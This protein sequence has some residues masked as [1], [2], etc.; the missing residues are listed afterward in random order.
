MYATL[1]RHRLRIAWAGFWRGRSAGARLGTLLA[2]LLGGGAIL[3]FVAAFAGATA[4]SVRETDPALLGALLSALFGTLAL[5][6]LSTETSPILHQLY[7]S[8]DIDLLLAAPVPA[9]SLFLLKLTQCAL[10]GAVTGIV[11]VAALVGYGVATGGA[12]PFYLMALPVIALV[13][14][15][16]TAATMIVLMLLTR[17]APAG[18]LRGVAGVLGALFGAVVW[19]LFQLASNRGT[20][21]AGR[22]TPGLERWQNISRPLPTTWAANALQTA[23]DGRYGAAA[24][25]IALLVGLTVA[26]VALAG[27]VFVRTFSDGHGRLNDVRPH[28]PRAV[29]RSNA[30]VSALLVQP[31]SPPVR[32]VILKEWRTLRR[33]V[34]AVTA[35][36]F[37]LVMVSFFG[38]RAL[39]NSPGGSDLSHVALF[40]ISLAPAAALPWFAGSTLATPALGREGRGIELLRSTPLRTRAL[41]IGKMVA[42]AAPVTVL[43]WVITVGV[44]VWR[45][46]GVPSVAVALVMG[47]WLAGGTTAADVAAGA[48][49]PRFEQDNPQRAVGFAGSI[50]GLVL[51]ALFLGSSAGLFGWLIAWALG[52]VSGGTATL[53]VSAVLAGIVAVVVAVILGVAALAAGRLDRWQDE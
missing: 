26:L 15:L 44:G 16:V 3:F 23:G 27:W 48:L 46:A 12:L 6:V 22:I 7:L 50:L 32:A 17:V 29:R 38:L 30:G 18:R 19:V 1:L 49:T 53:V 33:D 5:F 39:S 45:G 2:G 40:W 10:F 28:G 34:R 43:V 41:L 35:L 14:V 4:R 21:D 11:N 47:M 51:S 20:R 31:F 42:L 9:R 52:G 13:I 25:W 24:G 36:I 8:S 37:P